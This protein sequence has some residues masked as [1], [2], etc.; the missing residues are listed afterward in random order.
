MVS[1]CLYTVP[2]PSPCPLPPPRGRGQGEGGPPLQAFVYWL[3]RA[4]SLR[5]RG[6]APAPAEQ[7]D[8]RAHLGERVARSV[9]AID[10]RD[11]VEDDLPPLW[12]R[13]VNAARQGDRA[14]GDLLAAVRP[15][16]AGVGH[17]V[18]VAGQLHEN[19]EP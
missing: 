10:P 18:A 15:R 11:G 14:K 16:H 5:G 13:V 8:L 3:Q 9:D 6:A 4:R 1:T 17:V 19:A 12:L 7:I 2:P